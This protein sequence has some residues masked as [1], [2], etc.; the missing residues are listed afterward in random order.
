MF[1]AG[2]GN[3]KEMMK[4]PDPQCKSKGR[5]CEHLSE[6]ECICTKAD[7]YIRPE[8]RTNTC[9]EWCPIKP[10]KFSGLALYGAGGK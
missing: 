3:I 10:Y 5:K 7:R 1:D 9:P 8:D 4:N 6:F 2:T